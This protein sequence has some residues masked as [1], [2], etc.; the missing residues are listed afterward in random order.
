MSAA[1]FSAVDLDLLRRALFSS[2]ADDA[3]HA[4]IA[5]Y[6]HVLHDV[7]VA[8]TDADAPCVAATIMFAMARQLLGGPEGT[9]S[10]AACVSARR[11][12]EPPRLAA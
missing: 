3:D 5:L 1:S 11:L 2:D 6:L 10:A 12:P 4:T 7:K 9:P 8:F